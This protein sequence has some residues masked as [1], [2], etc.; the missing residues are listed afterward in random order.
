VHTGKFD[1]QEAIATA[2]ADSIGENSAS[3]GESW[4]ETRA[5]QGFL[6]LL[7]LKTSLPAALGHYQEAEQREKVLTWSSRLSM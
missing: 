6:C 7:G 4:A 3:D 5:R 2:E 1:G